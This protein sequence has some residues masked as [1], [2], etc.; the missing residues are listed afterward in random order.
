[1]CFLLCFSSHRHDDRNDHT[2]SGYIRNFNPS[3]RYVNGSPQHYL[4][5]F[6]AKMV[7]PSKKTKK[8]CSGQRALVS[9]MALSRMLHG[10]FSSTHHAYCT[11][12]SHLQT[13]CS[14]FLP[15]QMV[16][17]GARAESKSLGRPATPV[18]TKS[19]SA[20]D[21]PFLRIP[22]APSEVFTPPR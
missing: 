17:H 16:S 15:T 4:Q 1:M 12:T 5:Q 13:Q 7:G 6:G 18:F 10:D 19:A 22:D 14:R 8:P 9:P 11:P 20:I 21:E 2:H 3:N